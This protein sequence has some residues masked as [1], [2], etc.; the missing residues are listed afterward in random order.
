MAL[1]KT[2][3]PRKKCGFTGC[4]KSQFE[5]AFSSTPAGAGFAGLIIN[6]QPRV[7]VLLKF[8]RSLFSR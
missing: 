7:A 2:H 5:A 3:K 4:G 8:F 1:A 6:A